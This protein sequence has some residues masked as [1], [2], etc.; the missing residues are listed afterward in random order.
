VQCFFD[1]IGD[2]LGGAVDAVS[3]A[4]SDVFSGGGGEAPA[5]DVSNQSRPQPAPTPTP[6]PA[7][8][9]AQAPKQP[10][11]V[12]YDQHPDAVHREHDRDPEK[13]ADS[14]DLDSTEEDLQARRDDYRAHLHDEDVQDEN[15]VENKAGDVTRA[16]VWRALREIGGAYE[17]DF[18]RLL[19]GHSYGEQGGKDVVHNNYMGF[20]LW[21]FTRPKNDK[22]KF[23]RAL[24][25]EFITPAQYHANPDFF[26]NWPQGGVGTVKQQ[27]AAGSQKIG[28]RY[29]GPRAVYPTLGDATKAFLNGILWRVNACR[30]SSN[31]DYKELAK[32]VLA[33]D[34]DA[35]VRLVT[36]TD[37]DI[38]ILA[39]N[40][41]A[42]Y[43]AYIRP[44]LEKAKNDPKLSDDA[45]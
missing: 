29:P 12:R 45:P 24:R 41:N 42:G 5:P 13:P 1:D 8:T 9:P 15:F 3:N 23:T 17:K 36:L 31:D 25:S 37:K 14:Y 34:I 35:Y 26:W 20:E 30:D 38:K 2:A 32:N 40:N 18:L 43:G 44:H 28:V 10:A 21:G 19:V 27:L 22:R 11:K 6:T 16:D 33:G 4:V 39:Y 7:P